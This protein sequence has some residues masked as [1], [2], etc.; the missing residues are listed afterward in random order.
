MRQ[1]FSV[2][3]F[4]FFL[5]STSCVEKS[6]EIKKD[7]PKIVED[8]LIENHNNQEESVEMKPLELENFGFPDDIQGCSC[9]FSKSK[10]MFENDEYFFVANYDSLAHIKVDE[11]M[12]D[13]K[14]EMSTR[15]PNSFGDYDHKE[16]YTNDIY[17]VTVNIVYKKSSGY[18]TWLNEGTI[19]VETKDGQHYKHSIFG[20][21]GC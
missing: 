16:I 20:E 7:S 13:L 8:S 11:K 21:C 17:T 18:E 14:L 1:K 6:Q 4:I 9:Y 12:I 3:T 15:E 2:L 10:K 5:V 19:I